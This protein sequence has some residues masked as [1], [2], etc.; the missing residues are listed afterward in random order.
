MIETV[1][2][3]EVEQSD[4][5]A[6]TTEADFNRIKKKSLKCD[7]HTSDCELSTAMYRHYANQTQP[8]RLAQ[9]TDGVYHIETHHLIRRSKE[10]GAARMRCQLQWPRTLVGN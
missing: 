2:Q 7:D 3:N 1:K 5:G 9:E 4:I 8:L 10:L 6:T